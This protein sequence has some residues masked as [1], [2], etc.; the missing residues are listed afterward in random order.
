MRQDEKGGGIQGEMRKLWGVTDIVITLI[1]VMVS[2]VYTYVKAY[3]NI[4]N[5]WFIVCQSKSNKIVLKNNRKFAH[6][7][8]LT[9]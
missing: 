9:Q 6:V 1:V 3:R 7:L 5:M 2:W 8:A 4:L